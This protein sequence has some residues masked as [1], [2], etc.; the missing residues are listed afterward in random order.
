MS[1]GWKFKS[2]KIE[3]G[4]EEKNNKGSRNLPTVISNYTE[5]QSIV[6]QL[7]VQV[8]KTKIQC[9]WKK[10]NKRNRYLL[11]HIR[12]YTRRKLSTWLKVQECESIEKENNPR[13]RHLLTAIWNYIRRQ[14]PNWWHGST[15]R[16]VKIEY[17]TCIHTKYQL[18]ISTDRDLKTTLEDKRSHGLK[19]RSVKVENSFEGESQQEK[20]TTSNVDLKLHKTMP[21]VWTQRN[22]EQKRHNAL[23]ATTVTYICQCH[24]LS[25]SLEKVYPPHSNV[26]SCQCD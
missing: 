7:K 16:C 4:V 24:P 3:Y 10:N 2:V 5:R 14:L 15:F 19:F 11:T 22:N 20:Q 26:F 17:S 21:G 8:C 6:T 23:K 25:N 12:N 13:N 9:W 1:S 18:Y